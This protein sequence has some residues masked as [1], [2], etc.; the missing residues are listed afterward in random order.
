MH[1]IDMLREKFNQIGLQLKEIAARN[2]CMVRD[3]N[4]EILIFE[5]DPKI[6]YNLKSDEPLIDWHA[7]DISHEMEL[8]KQLNSK[9]EQK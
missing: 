3:E 2:D 1:C 7:V 8:L 4:G 6:S 9:G 5:R